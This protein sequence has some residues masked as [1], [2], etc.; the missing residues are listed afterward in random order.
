MIVSK[1]VPAESIRVHFRSQRFG[2]AQS[3]SNSSKGGSASLSLSS[4]S[5]PTKMLQLFGG[6]SFPLFN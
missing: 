5:S 3:R 6:F 1:V 4:S 2:S